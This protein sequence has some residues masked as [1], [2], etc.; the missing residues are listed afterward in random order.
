MVF[1]DDTL[2]NLDLE[3]LTGLADQFSG[4]ERHIPFQNVIAILG[5]KHKVVLDFENRMAR[6]DSPSL[7]PTLAK[8]FKDKSDRL[9]PVVLTLDIEIKERRNDFGENLA[10]TR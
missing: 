4:L 6:I 7:L 10:N 5:N 1:A 8:G 2:E 9:K 3:R